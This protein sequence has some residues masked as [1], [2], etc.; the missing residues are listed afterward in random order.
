MLISDRGPVIP[1]DSPKIWSADI[2][3]L[4]AINAIPVLAV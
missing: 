1:M 3:S 4:K 2:S